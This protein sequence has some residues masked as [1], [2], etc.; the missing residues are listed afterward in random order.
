MNRDNCKALLGGSLGP[1][2]IV[3]FSLFQKFS[4]VASSLFLQGRVVE[5][6][7]CGAVATGCLDVE[8]GM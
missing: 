3:V 5:Y 6:K 4:M 7:E 1:V 8:V 2:I